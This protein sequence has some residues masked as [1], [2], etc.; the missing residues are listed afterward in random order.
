MEDNGISYY[1]RALRFPPSQTLFANRL[2]MHLIK[3]A[4]SLN[5]MLLLLVN[6]VSASERGT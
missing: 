2:K 5:V 3:L 4:F 6:F 1:A